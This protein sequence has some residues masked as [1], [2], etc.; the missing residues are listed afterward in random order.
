MD[1]NHPHGVLTL[2]PP[3]IRI[4]PQMH[5]AHGTRVGAI[6]LSFS[7]SLVAFGCG[8]R[9]DVSSSGTGGT[10]GSVGVDNNTGSGGTSSGSSQP[11]STTPTKAPNTTPPAGALNIGSGAA[12]G[13][14]VPAGLG[15][16]SL[17]AINHVHATID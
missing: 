1:M 14:A 4:G 9:P 15:L 3:S 11:S 16:P 6:G 10:G 7:I 5:K 2:H 8:S 17:P 12:D 13:T